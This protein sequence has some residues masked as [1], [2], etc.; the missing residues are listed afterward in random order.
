M[1][2]TSLGYPVSGTAVWFRANILH[3]GS[4]GRDARF[5]ARPELVIRRVANEPGAIGYLGYPLLVRM[6]KRYQDYPVKVIR[7]RAD[8]LSP[9][10]DPPAK[11]AARSM[12]P[13]VRPLFLYWDGKSAS[14]AV[15]Q[16]IEFCVGRATRRQ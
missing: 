11:P 16:F 3:K 10:F 12:Y 1:A 15:T 4:F 2:P 6:L 7:M 9:G 13:L 5:R 8:K 14:G